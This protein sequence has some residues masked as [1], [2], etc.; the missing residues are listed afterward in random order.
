ME[1]VN[2]WMEIVNEWM[3]IVNEWMEIMER[4]EQEQTEM[5]EY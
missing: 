3:E 4:R 5:W 2:E 1:I